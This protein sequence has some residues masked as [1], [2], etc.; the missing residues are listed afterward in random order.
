MYYIL[1]GTSTATGW[2]EYE[3][4]ELALS[5]QPSNGFFGFQVGE[6]ANNK[7]ANHGYSGWFYYIGTFEG[8]D[9]MGTGDVFADIDCSLPWGIEREYTVTDCSGNTTS[10]AYTVDVNGLTCEPIEPT[11]DS[12]DDNDDNWSDDPIGDDGIGLD[13]GSNDK[14]SIKV[15]GLTPNPA[16]D[17]ALLTFMTESD[18]QVGVHLYGASG[19]LVATLWEGQVFADVPMN[20]EVPASM[21][22]NGL[23]QI[24]IL[25]AS[26]TVTTKLLVNN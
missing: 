9:V 25:S 11:L 23:Y 21:L 20:I 5:H 3:G 13:D 12:N 26:G 14:P 22:E 8:A 6:G 2:G 4:S 7:N 15:L 10:F 18:A 17:I 16:S 1:Q 24:Q 19:M